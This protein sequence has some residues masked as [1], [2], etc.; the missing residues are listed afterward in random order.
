MQFAWL[1]IRRSLERTIVFQSA[2]SHFKAIIALRGRI[3]Y[4][5]F[6]RA[7][8]RGGLSNLYGH[9]RRLSLQLFFFDLIEIKHFGVDSPNFR[10][11][12]YVLKFLKSPGY[13]GLLVWSEVPAH[14][15]A[16]RHKRLHVVGHSELLKF[17]GLN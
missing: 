14:G 2:P 12:L 11:V 15:D 7:V 13:F 10:W 16:L 8:G 9:H 5:F 17:E 3:L 6:I 4:R 1:R